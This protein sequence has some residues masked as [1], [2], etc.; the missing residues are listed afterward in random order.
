MYENILKPILF[1]FNPETVHNLFVYFGEFLGNQYL[2]LFF[3]SAFSFELFELYVPGSSW[4]PSN[5]IKA[6][7]D[8][9]GYSGRKR[10]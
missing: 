7:T 4:N 6:S 1:K 3:P 5:E 2:I 9:E 8:S 10:V